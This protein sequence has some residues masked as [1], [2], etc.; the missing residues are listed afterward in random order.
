MKKKREEWKTN[1]KTKIGKK[2]KRMDAAFVQLEVL[3]PFTETSW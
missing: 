3:K 2:W 1:L